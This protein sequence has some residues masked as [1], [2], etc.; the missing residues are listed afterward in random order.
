[1]LEGGIKAKMRRKF[2]ITTN[3]NHKLSVAKNLLSTVITITRAN[4]VWVGDITYIWTKEGGLYLASVMDL[5]SRKTI[6]WCVGIRL[7]KELVIKALRMVIDAR[8]IEKGLII[9]LR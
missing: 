8:K 5:W 1:M 2:I 3:S 9:S 4:M 7:V 6:G